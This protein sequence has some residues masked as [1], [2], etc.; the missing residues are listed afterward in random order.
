MNEFDY[1][2]CVNDPFASFKNIRRLF[3]QADESAFVL[4]NGST[5]VSDH[6]GI[7]AA[8]G[9]SSER[10]LTPALDAEAL[11]L[12]KTISRDHI[13]VS[14][15]GIV[16]PVVISRAC[17]GLMNMNATVADCGSFSPPEVEHLKISSVPAECPSTGTALPVDL[18]NE[19]FD[20]G[21]ELGKKLAASHKFIVVA[22][23]V[24]GGTT[25]A[26]AVLT[27]LGIEANGLLSSSVLSCNH[28]QRWQLVQEGI[29]KTSASK[30]QVEANSLLAIA[31]VGDPMQ[32]FVSGLSLAASP[33]VP[34]I[35]AGGSQM[36]AV[37]AILNKL[38]AS[39]K[40]PINR[41]QIFVMTT[42]WVAFDPNA[43][44]QK[45]ALLTNA[46]LVASCPDFNL[47]R[48]PGLRAYEA[49]H[50]KE[51]VGA[52]ALMALSHL[53]GFPPE[54]ILATIDNTYDTIVPCT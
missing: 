21:F 24:P 45:L 6:E 11:L 31:A 54:Q 40:L 2:K 43:A 13:P 35:L 39:R 10:R 38:A 8:G 1:V 7:S 53:Q 19:L 3:Q 27:M 52:G 46:P 9:S 16:S 30:A 28:Q 23:C 20:K 26:L 14:P 15:V 47:S 42:K 34:V 36:L 5:K 29:S 17:L 50:V 12:G 18:V 32:A 41:E 48:H 37:W 44:V 33:M 49:G 25:T 22:E 4:C 51:G